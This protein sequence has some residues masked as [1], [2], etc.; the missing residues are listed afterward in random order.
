M[1][2]KGLGTPGLNFSIFEI[3]LQHCSHDFSPSFCRKLRT[4]TT[5]ESGRHHL[6]T[7]LV[8]F[9]FVLVQYTK[10]VFCYERINNLYFKFFAD[11]K[12]D[13][14]L[15][16]FPKLKYVGIELWQASLFPF[17]FLHYIV[18]PK[19]VFI[20]LAL[21][22]EREIILQVKSGTLFDN[23]LI[24]DDPEYAKQLAEETWAKQKD[25]CYLIF[26]LW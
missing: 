8:H 15:Y 7:T 21:S 9:Q 12:D 11:F 2:A 20:C 23:V 26:I 22:D 3:N 17:A 10:L 13:P 19:F 1:E 24:T 5:V 6:L 4:P 25:V 18:V 16:V 14:D